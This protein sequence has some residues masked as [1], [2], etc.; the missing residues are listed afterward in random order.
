[1]FGLY[2]VAA[3]EASA[4]TG[5]I[6]QTVTDVTSSIGTVTSWWIFPIAITFFVA[7]TLLNLILG[8]FCKR[9]R[10]RRK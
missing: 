7:G 5:A 6:T 4:I 8:F 3:P 1:M 10:R 2:A 9:K